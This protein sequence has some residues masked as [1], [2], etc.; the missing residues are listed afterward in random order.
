MSSRHFEPPPSGT[1]R[2]KFGLD[3]YML[4]CGEWTCLQIIELGFIQ[5]KHYRHKTVTHEG[6]TGM[7]IAWVPQ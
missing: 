6:Q 2:V 4:G 5:N 7:W 3:L 1:D